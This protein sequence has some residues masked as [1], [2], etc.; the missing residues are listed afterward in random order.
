MLVI[1]PLKDIFK[2]FRVEGS[3]KLVLSFKCPLEFNIFIFWTCKWNIVPSTLRKKKNGEVYK[4]K[5]NSE[6]ELNM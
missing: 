4:V 6:S 3:S 5:K 1:F 2:P